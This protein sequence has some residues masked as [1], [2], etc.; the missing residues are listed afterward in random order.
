MTSLLIKTICVADNGNDNLD[1]IIRGCIRKKEKSQEML[2]KRFFGHALKVALIY[3]RDRENAIEVVNDS[4]VK[5]FGQI[6]KY[7]SSKPFKS[8]MNRILINTSIDSYR[9]NGTNLQI[10]EEKL[11][12]I[13]DTEPGVLNNITAEEILR[14]LNYLPD[15]QRL[16]FS[17]YEIEGYSHEEV[18]SVLKI[19]EN[20]SRVYLARAKK[21]L[22]ELF[23][24]YFSINYE[25]YGN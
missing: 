1:E 22:R 11:V 3:N 25:R 14:L 16:V 20:S 18:A 2:Y 15:I 9:K 6:N 5:I 12:L 13:P 8:W 24:I 21:R 17:M 10:E 7:D 23:Q 4:F 19:A